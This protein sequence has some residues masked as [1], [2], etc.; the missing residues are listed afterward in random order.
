MSVGDAS[1]AAEAKRR[2]GEDRARISQHAHDIL[3]V[4]RDS[5]FLQSFLRV[6]LGESEPERDGVVRGAGGEDGGGNWLRVLQR[7]KAGLHGQAGHEGGDGPSSGGDAGGQRVGNRLARAAVALGGGGGRGRAG[8]GDGM[9]TGKK[10]TFSQLRHDL[11]ERH[12]AEG[13]VSPPARIEG[14]EGLGSMLVADQGAG[15]KG[16]RRGRQRSHEELYTDKDRAAAVNLGTRDIKQSLKLKRK[17]DRSQAL[18]IPEEADPGAMLALGRRQMKAGRVS[19]A[20]GFVNKALELQPE[21]VEALVSRSRCYLAVGQPGSALK[22]AEAALAVEPGCIRG[23]YQKAEALY[24]LGD[25]EHSLVFYHR[26]QRIRPEMEC[27]RLGVQKAQEAIQNTIGK[28]GPPTRRKSSSVAPSKS[29]SSPPVKSH[30]AAMFRKRNAPGSSRGT[31]DSG[32]RSSRQ[33]LGELCIDKL[34]LENLLQHPD[35]KAPHQ[36]G[37]AHIAG[38]AEEA[39]AYLAGRE[40]FWRQQ[41]KV[42]S[43]PQGARTAQRS[44]NQTS[45]GRA[46]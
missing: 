13:V 30:T 22:D 2:G 12:G 4:P 6:D 34:Y 20:L 8:S 39:V 36:E 44:R 7:K 18:Q 46:R 3:A 17:Q 16:R 23:I 43:G 40:E 10:T 42:N 14:G 33:L 25:F 41:K 21:D 28:K 35:I 24:H 5:E 26:G 27:F 37:C 15:K 45:S 29:P 1:S 11:R 9:L 32:G 19:V 38:P 31:P